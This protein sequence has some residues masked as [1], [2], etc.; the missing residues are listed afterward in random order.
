MR[1]N[2]TCFILLSSIHSSGPAWPAYSP[3]DCIRSARSSSCLTAASTCAND[4]STNGA[5]AI[6]MQSQPRAMCASWRRT[7]SRIKR[8]ALFRRTA[9]PM[10]LLLTKPKRLTSRPFGA[11]ASTTS[12]WA[13]E[14]PSRRTRSKS[15]DRL[16]RYC[17]SMG[18]LGPKHRPR[19][20]LPGLKRL[21]SNGSA[22]PSS[23]PF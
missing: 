3:A 9:L 22:K 8:L 1:P 11:A 7:D 6:K 10:R 16:S 23:S 5:R 14:S 19:I 15:R 2:A 13:H 4:A 20:Q 17:R 12:G 21:P 18:G